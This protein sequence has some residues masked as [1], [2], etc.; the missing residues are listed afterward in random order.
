[1]AWLCEFLVELRVGEH[2][3]GAAARSVRRWGRQKR[4]VMALK[5]QT[6]DSKTGR[7]LRRGWMGLFEMDWMWL[8][9]REN[10][11]DEGLCTIMHALY[12]CQMVS[13]CVLYLFLEY[14]SLRLFSVSF[15]A[16]EVCMTSASSSGDHRKPSH[17]K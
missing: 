1:M 10:D 8:S 5:M 13:H 17:A 4:R 15:R 6:D 14:L 11:V 2:G 16:Y 7:A 9:S 12:L 3:H